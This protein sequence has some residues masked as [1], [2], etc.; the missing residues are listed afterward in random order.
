[1]ASALP[2]LEETW[3][4]VQEAKMNKP[5]PWLL[6]SLNPFLQNPRLCGLQREQV[7]STSSAY[8]DSVTNPGTNML[9]IFP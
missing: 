1:M 3:A 9:Y 7:L 8:Q 6:V 2:L 5:D 4:R